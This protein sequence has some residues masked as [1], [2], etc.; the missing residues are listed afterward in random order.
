MAEMNATRQLNPKRLSILAALLHVMKKMPKNDQYKIVK[1]IFLADRKHLNV[2]GRPITFDNPWALEWGPVPRLTYNALKPEFTA[3]RQFQIASAPWKITTEG[4][5]HHFN[6]TAEPDYSQLSGSDVKVLDEIIALV[7]TL[8]F[9]AVHALAK[10]D[11]AYLE[12][13]PQRGHKSS[14]PMKLE[15]LLDEKDSEAR[16]EIIS[17]VALAG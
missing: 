2:Y 9:N 3:W 11:P 8:D 4:N 6:P 16:E 17:D 15:L 14:V 13:W 5:I 10:D 1:T 12:A 7:A